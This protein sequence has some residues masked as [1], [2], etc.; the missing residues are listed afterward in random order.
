MFFQNICQ[1]NGP[2]DIETSTVSIFCDKKNSRDT[3]VML[4]DTILNDLPLYILFINL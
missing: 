1:S 2:S 4:L 3:L